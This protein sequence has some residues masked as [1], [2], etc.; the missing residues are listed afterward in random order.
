MKRLTNDVK[1]E[2]T[3]EQKSTMV[4][5]EKNESGNILELALGV[6][7]LPDG[8][9]MHVVS[10]DPTTGESRDFHRYM[11]ESPS[12]L[13]LWNAGFVLASEVVQ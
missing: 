9:Y 4:S 2:L 8:H 5:V 7:G 13:L 6:Q 12:S 11:G 3:A 1:L 10:P